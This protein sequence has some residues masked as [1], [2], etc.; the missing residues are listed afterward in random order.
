MIIIIRRNDTNCIDLASVATAVITLSTASI[1][2]DTPLLLFSLIFYRLVPLYRLDSLFC[3]QSV[4]ISF[5]ASPTF[6]GGAFF[7]TCSVA[8]G[9]T[10]L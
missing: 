5:S 1:G 10:D 2:A 6:N 7:H 8:P 3:P 9:T 4:D